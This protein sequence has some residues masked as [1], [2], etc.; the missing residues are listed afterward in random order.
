MNMS[1]TKLVAGVAWAGLAVAS[2]APAS[3]IAVTW[4]SGAFASCSASYSTGPR[5]KACVGDEGS[6]LGY[7]QNIKFVTPGCSSGPCSTD[8]GIV[9][10]DQI[11]GVGRK[12]ATHQGTCDDGRN[13]YALGSCA[14]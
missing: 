9:H 7:E 3:A 10:T 5:P 6:P 8:S 1:I 12:V 4:Q 14:C 11:Y 2:A 13:I